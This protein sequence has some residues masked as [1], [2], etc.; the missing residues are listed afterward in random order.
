MAPK[1]AEL[2]VPLKR[3]FST[4]VFRDDYIKKPESINQEL[5]IDNMLVV[6]EAK[7]N[8]NQNILILASALFLKLDSSYIKTLL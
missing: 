2:F 3:R 5:N 7:V 6:T 4:N 8:G 1:P